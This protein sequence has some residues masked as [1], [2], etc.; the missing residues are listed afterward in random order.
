MSYDLDSLA[1]NR[2]Y[3]TLPGAFT[4]HPKYDPATGELH[5]MVYA[6]PDLMDHVQYVVVGW[7]VA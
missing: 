5:A 2:F 3:G 7:T 1:L 4:A 6:W